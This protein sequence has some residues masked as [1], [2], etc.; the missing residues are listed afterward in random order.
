M[1]EKLGIT[2]LVSSAEDASHNDMNTSS[3]GLGGLTHG[4]TTEEVA[5]A[6]A[7]FANNGVYNSPRLYV[8][9]TDN[10]G[11]VILDNQAETHVAMKETTA[12]FMN[13]LLQGVVNGGTGSS[14]N[15]GNM[16]I[17]GKTGTTS[18]NY[19][20]Y[21]A[22]Y[23]PYYSAAVWTGYKNN[24]KI[25]YSGNPALVMWKKVMSRIHADLPYK[26]FS[27]PSSGIS[28]LT[29]CMDSG[30]LAGDA[31]A[32]DARTLDGGGSRVQTVEVAT[33]TGPTEYCTMHTVVD[34]C[35][36]GHTLAGEF[37]PAESVEQRAFLDYVRE[38]YG[39]NV[40]ASDNAYLLA[41]V[42]AL[43]GCPVHTEAPVVEDP[44]VGEDLTDPNGGDPSGGSDEPDDPNGED[45][46]VGDANWFENLWNYAVPAEP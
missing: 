42:Q 33:G 22:G 3:L 25:V 14:A 36:E 18:D 11:N 17:A 23:T 46:T 15:F 20:R 21:F 19:D 5:A 40:T 31:C 9:V 44:D 39:D 32:L 38:N 45:P 10:Q 43:G 13:K 16:A 27:K 1:T 12:Y 30:M 28:T 35:T 41:T 24:E 34:Y 26:S 4:V 2:T 6:Y 8:K 37:C 29:V 7:A